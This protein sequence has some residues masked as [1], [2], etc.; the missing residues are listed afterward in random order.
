MIGRDNYILIKETKITIFLFV[1]TPILNG[2]THTY[3]YTHTN[4]VQKLLTNKLIV[5]YT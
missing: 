5:K 2:I 3:T 4:K 1:Y